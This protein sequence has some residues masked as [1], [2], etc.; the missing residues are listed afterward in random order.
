MLSY[1]PPLDR[2]LPHI[3]GFVST[4]LRK[5]LTAE[6]PVGGPGFGSGDSTQDHQK[7]FMNV[8]G[9]VTGL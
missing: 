5:S 4:R 6:G 8:R 2:I 1:S 9:T 3:P 7:D